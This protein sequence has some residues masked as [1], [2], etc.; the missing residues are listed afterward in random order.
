MLLRFA[1][2]A[3]IFLIGIGTSSAANCGG[4]LYHPCI[5][6]TDKRYD[7]NV[8]ADLDDIDPI[9]G[10]YAGHWHCTVNDFDGNT[11]P[12]KTNYVPADAEARA[13]HSNRPYVLTDTPAFM[14]VAVDGTRLT[15]NELRIYAPPSAEFCAGTPDDM[16]TNIMD[17]GECGT[18]GWA[19]GGDLVR[20]STHNKDEYAVTAA[21]TGIF[22][23][24]SDGHDGHH[25]EGHH[26]E[27][28]HEEGHDDEGTH[29]EGHDD[30]E[31][32][33]LRKM[34]NEAHLRRALLRTV[35]QDRHLQDHHGH[36]DGHGGGGGVEHPIHGA[37]GILFSADSSSGDSL[38]Y[39][40]K[41]FSQDYSTFVMRSGSFDLLQGVETR[42]SQYIC[43]RAPQVN[44]EAALA[45]AY[46]DANVTPAT[47]DATNFVAKGCVSDC[48][49]EEEICETDPS[50]S[51]SPYQEPPG[52][53][54]G[55]A[56]AGITVACVIVVAAAMAAFFQY[57]MKQQEKRNKVHFCKAIAKHINVQSTLT[58][59]QLV[60]EFQNVDTSHDGKINKAELKEFL[61]TGKLGEINDKDFE[62]L[63]SVMDAD[64]SGDVDFLEFCTYLGNCHEVYEDLSTHNRSK[65]ETELAV[66]QSISRRNLNVDN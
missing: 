57:R 51:V 54:K 40:I 9:W 12:A 33:H 66:A 59:D 14:K 7:P 24:G 45:K 15:I 26:E 63:W 28:H 49:S 4:I 1:S 46:D 55:G 56:V 5:G 61:D 38:V 44:F 58:P 39:S 6:E 16:H 35:R 18:N 31:H 41:S 34:R 62:T 30:E 17:D 13:S 53:L 10:Q 20:T 25:E 43:K 19:E 3:P 32:N 65:G 47:R 27:G 29:E 23:I 8:S 36:G 60:A 42:T 52:S 64:G 37:E 48:P 21:S 2:I 11:Q 50:C 22:T